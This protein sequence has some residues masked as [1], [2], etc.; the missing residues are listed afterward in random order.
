MKCIHNS[1]LHSVHCQFGTSNHMLLCTSLPLFILEPVIHIEKINGFQLFTHNPKGEDISDAVCR[2]LATRKSNIKV[3]VNPIKQYNIEETSFE[4][5]CVKYFEENFEALAA[6][7]PLILP[8]KEPEKFK[9]I[10]N[11]MESWC[12][13]SNKSSRFK[14]LVL[15]NF[16]VLIHLKHFG[17]RRDAL[18]GT[19]KV[20]AFSEAPIIVVY[21]PKE[22]VILLIRNAQTQD[23]ETDINIGFDDLKMFIL[24]FYDELEGTNL[25]LISLVVI[26]K[27]HDFN[28]NCS[29]CINNVLSLEV[30]NDL[31][32]FEN[33][34]E[35]RATY[36]EQDSV[37]VINPDCI[38]NFLAKITGTVASTFIYGKYIPTL[39]DKSDEKITNL[40]VLLTPEQMDIVNSKNKHIIV[41]G[42]FGCGKTVIAAAMMR[43][44]SESLKN[45]EKLYYICYDCRSELLDQT[46]KDAQIED[47]SNIT[48]FHNKEGLQLS[49]IIR[50]ILDKKES[51]KQVNFIVDE[52]DGEDLD[53]SE[54][55]SLNTV[56]NKSLK[57]MF[58]LLLVQPIEKE[59]I[60]KN[61]L[62][63]KN[64]FDLLENIKLYHLNRVMRNSLEISNLVRLT[65]D[66][67]MN[68]QTVFM[69]QED[70]NMKSK[71]KHIVR[72][73]SVRVKNTVTELNKSVPDSTT[74][75]TSR[76]RDAHEY[77]KKKMV[78]D[79]AKSPTLHRDPHEY[80]EHSNYSSILK[81][82]LDEAQAISRLPTGTRK[83]G[84]KTITQFQYDAV[85]K[86][87]HKISSNKPELFELGDKSDFQKVLSL[88]A[89]FEKREIERGQQVVLHFNTVTNEIPN[90]LLFVF[91]NH[92][93]IQQRVTNKYKDFQ[94]P[95]K[96]VLVCSYPTFR[97]LEHG[98]ITVVIDRDIYF[99]QHYLV[100]AIARC[101]TDLCIVILQ[102]S[103][104]L[105]AITGE[106]KNKEAVQKCE[107]KISEDS[108]LQGDFVLDFMHCRNTTTISAKLRREY[109]KMLENI[110]AESMTALTEVKTIDSKMKIEA[111]KII[112]QR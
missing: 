47:D 19:F 3:K 70:E 16:S 39:T 37:K 29:D 24:L 64:R 85:G 33:W 78:L 7:G 53:E 43:K 65:I 95:K 80:P 67:L 107:I 68:R 21:N 38:K 14:G 100:E 45:D 11:T 91:E 88:I 103:L 76:Q 109:Y 90:S 92:F 32:I 82:G 27:T 50:D 28:L 36:Y 73:V 22:N 102:N 110:F 75:W 13:K 49:E 58:F 63:K 26:D 23:L 48:L 93:K 51:E 105:T 79:E 84:Y 30:F 57:Q 108:S 61:I 97:G 42:G 44:I 17:F 20:K 4:K 87:G 71:F 40:T 25:K 106:W 41:R 72:N 89:V 66:V 5:R 104:T 83:E 9:N 15:H 98:K 62:L 86:T 101:T 1:R 55:K 12:Q 74:K 81:M 94:S 10:I 59:R 69:H 56:L 18:R 31:P 112:L 46:R 6:E 52:Y 54:A 35:E 111:R 8:C 60:I 77:S 99:V 96:S 34:W 2:I